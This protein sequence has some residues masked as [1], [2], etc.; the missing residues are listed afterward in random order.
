MQHL[1]CIE[2]STF[3]S[4]QVAI[5]IVPHKDPKMS[6]ANL[7]N[8]IFHVAA[9]TIGLG[10]GFTILAIKKGT[11]L[12]LRL[13]KYF[14][15]SAIAVCFSAAIGL[16]FFR[17]LPLFAVL[18]VLVF[19]QLISGW[20]AAHTKHAGP[21]TIDAV[22]TAFGA[23]CATALVP[24]LISHQEMATPTVIYST[25][26][27]LATIL[28]YDVV[29]WTFPRSWHETLWIYEHVYKMIGTL[30]GLLSA[31][32][33]NVVRFGQPW[34]QVLPSA[35]GILF[36]GWFFSKIYMRKNGYEFLSLSNM[37]ES[38]KP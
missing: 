21:G 25:L 13:G 30:F 11:P 10:L 20:R 2:S 24:I 8:V 14:A 4:T 29:R 5:E 32:V 1:G 26:G 33:G 15:Y 34:S 22:W 12:H 31:F 36:V 6:P 9:G 18:T 16:V 7:I 19:Y 27:G 35:I 23:V 38:A 37:Q 3:A 28:F 17:F